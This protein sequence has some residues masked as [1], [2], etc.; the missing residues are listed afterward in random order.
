MKTA[1]STLYLLLV[2]ISPA[3]AG[4]TTVVYKSGILVSVFVGLCALIVVAQLVPVLMMIVGFIKG[5]VAAA[6]KK[7]APAVESAPKGN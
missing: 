2:L 7:E 5:S 1:I 3:I 6:Y 4:D